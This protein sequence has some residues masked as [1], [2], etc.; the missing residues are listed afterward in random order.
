MSVTIQETNN[1]K[2]QAIT[3]DDEQIREMRETLLSDYASRGNDPSHINRKNSLFIQAREAAKTLD[4]AGFKWGAELCDEVK[5]WACV[6]MS[7]ALVSPRRR[8]WPSFMPMFI[9]VF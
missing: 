9:E 5:A 3:F 2:V 7:R 6:W 8:R 1:T 4:A